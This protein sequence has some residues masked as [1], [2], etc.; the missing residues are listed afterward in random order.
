MR[1]KTKLNKQAYTPE[2]PQELV[3]LLAYF[4]AYILLLVFFPYNMN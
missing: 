4:Y 3:K 1:M 2:L